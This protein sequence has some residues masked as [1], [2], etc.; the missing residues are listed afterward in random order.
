MPSDTFSCPECQVKLRRSADLRIGDPVQCPRCRVQFPVPQPEEEP[1]GQTQGPGP[2]ANLDAFSDAVGTG[3]ANVDARAEAD[4]PRDSTAVSTRPAEEQRLDIDEQRWTGWRGDEDA[5]QS[6]GR[7]D[8]LAELSRGYRVERGRWFALAR[9]HWGAILG[10]AVG[11]LLI[12]YIAHTVINWVVTIGA[13][14]VLSGAGGFGPGLMVGPGMG[15]IEMA[16]VTGLLTLGSEVLVA[17]PLYS[18]LTAVCLAQL[19]GRPWTFGTFFA[20]L[21]MYPATALVGLVRAVLFV[22]VQ[23]LQYLAQYSF[24]LWFGGPFDEELLLVAGVAL[25]YLMLYA[26]LYVRLTLFARPLIF[27]RHFG[28]I[29]ALAGSWKLSRGHFWGLLGVFLVTLLVDAGGAVLCGVGLLFTVPLTTL[30]VTAGYLLAAGTEAPLSA[31]D[32]GGRAP[33]RRYDPEEED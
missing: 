27:D 25:L 32:F 19:K 18:G 9:E 29:E 2:A 33:W 30:V 26:Y 16:I 21:R 13:T 4:R 14:L 17:A 6:I 1:A 11:F 20:G 15:M 5:D 22:P 12:A 7:P 10:Q 23:A 8:D 28:G 24:G 31:A 3:A